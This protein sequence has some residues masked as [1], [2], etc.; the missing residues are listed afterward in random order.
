M[1]QILYMSIMFTLLSVFLIGLYGASVGSVDLFNTIN[2][3]SGPWPTIS[4]GNCQF[5][6]AGFSGSCNVL[7]AAEL[8]TV[9]IFAVV[10]SVLYRIGA[11]FYLGYQ[12]FTILN[13]FRSFPYLGWFFGSLMLIMTLEF[14]KLFRSGHTS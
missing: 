9:W 4:N 7:D 10:G 3:V 1:G 14:W 12:F 6:S 11:L 2:Q 8:G 13:S 5:S